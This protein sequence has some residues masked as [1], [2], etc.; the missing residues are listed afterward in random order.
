MIC[1]FGLWDT[2]LAEK[3]ND[4]SE[5]RAAIKKKSR[6]NSVWVGNRVDERL[7]LD[8]RMAIRREANDFPFVTIRNETEKLRESGE[9]E[10]KRI[11]EVDCDDGI[12]AS[13]AA[14]PDRS[15]FP[16]AAAIDN[17]DS[18]IVET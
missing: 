17:D 7:K 10:A 2:R 15:S 3:R 16:S 18:G 1:D 13:I 14:V 5:A 4:R 11:G 8:T 6:M 12:E 9:E